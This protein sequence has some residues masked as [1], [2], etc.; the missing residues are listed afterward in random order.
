MPGMRAGPGLRTVRHKGHISSEECW[1]S[2][3]LVMDY[4]VEQEI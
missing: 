2:E 3:F 1:D 4:T